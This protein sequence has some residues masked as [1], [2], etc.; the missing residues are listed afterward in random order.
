MTQPTPRP[1]S[2]QPAELAAD[3]FLIRTAFAAAGDE[4]TMYQSSMV[5]RG[6]QPILVD[7][8]PAAAGDQ[9]LDAVFALVDPEDVRWVFVSHND[10]DHNGNVVN[11]LAACP[12]AT[13]ITTS[14]AVARMTSSFDLPYRR[15]QWLNFGDTF[16]AGDRTIEI[17]DVPVYDSP[18]T[19]GLFDRATGVMWAVDAFAAVVP[20]NDPSALASDLPQPEWEDVLR[21]LGIA[22]NPWLEGAR[23]DW[24]T[25]RLKEI[26]GR[27]PSV[28]ANAH[29]P[30]LTGTYIDRAIE[31]YDQLPGTT[32]P[33]GPGGD[34]LASLLA[35]HHG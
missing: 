18:V 13:L 6:A 1:I 10:S 33:P 20:T 23:P 22:A 8:G 16:D 24:F 26:S 29:G 17:I 3:T 12:Q 31:I 35:A 11:V 25:S 32:P 2:Y 4:M 5:I 34:A 14:P 15:M 21:G 28:V 7:T 19:Q 30:A 27:G 9:W